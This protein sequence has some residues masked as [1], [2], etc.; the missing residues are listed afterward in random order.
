MRAI[1]S[2]FLVMT[3]QVM[4]NNNASTIDSAMAEMIANYQPRRLSPT[5]ADKYLA[6]VK[7][8]VR[9]AQPRNCDRA[10]RLLHATCRLIE[11]VHPVNDESLVD[12]L[13]ELSI[14]FWESNTTLGVDDR[15][16]VKRELRRLNK[17]IRRFPLDGPIPSMG[18]PNLR[19]IDITELDSLVTAC[20]DDQQALGAV[21]A[22][23]G[24]GARAS[25][26]GDCR[27]TATPPRC[28]YLGTERRIVGFDEEVLNRL[29]G[30][31]L[32]VSAF[33]RVERLVRQMGLS[34]DA[35]S[36]HSHFVAQVLSQPLPFV[37]IL[38]RFPL[39]VECAVERVGQVTPVSASQYKEYLRG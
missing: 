2:H 3:V 1:A 32:R 5:L 38:T 20:T 8:L 13:S 10:R 25:R 7:T 34:I 16:N 26:L 35:Y 15:S 12:L 22:L 30:V 11:D 27:F 9:E 37:E 36:L 18:R 21:V 39:G 14:A 28:W 6:E 23:A 19:G 31:S 24:A 29:N 33:T 17:T 4:T